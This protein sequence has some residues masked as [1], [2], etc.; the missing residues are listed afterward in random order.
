MAQILVT[1]LRILIVAALTGCGKNASHP[2][3]RPQVLHVQRIW[4]SAPHNAFTDLTR[5]R[6]KWYCVCREGRD[7]ISFDGTIRVLTSRDGRGWRAAATLA[8]PEADLRDAKLAPTPDNRLML[9]AGAR[10]HTNPPRVQSVVWF[11]RD[12][13]HWAGPWQVA[14]SNY[15]LWRVTWHKD[16]CYGI[17]YACGPEHNIRLYRS[18][19]DTT[20]V[21]LAPTL[22]NLDYANEAALVFA[23]DDSLFCLLRR[24]PEQALLGISGPPYQHWRWLPLGARIGGPHMLSLPDGRLVAAV[25]LYD[26]GPRTA[27]CWV[28]KR[29]G[30]LTEF[31]TL[32]SGGDTGYPGLV[33]YKKTLWVSYYS[34]HEGK[35]A[36]Y[37]AQVK[38]PRV[39]LV[40]P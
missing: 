37:V 4:D 31:L 27:L 17:G 16:R 22:Y 6:G 7:H 11:S 3:D 20:F 23:R 8:L 30:T 38:L 2:P 9:I 33:W 13:N 39:E 14:D 19:D 5:F 1:I 21:P 25:R 15:W 32:P 10:F 18:Q 40:E 12:G 29:R 26:N 24:D 28:D 35:A 36:V 34:S